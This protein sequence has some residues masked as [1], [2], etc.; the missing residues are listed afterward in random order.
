MD[1][2][3]LRYQSGFGNDFASEGLP[4]ALPVGQ[5]NPQKPAYGLYTEEINGTPFTAPR[6]ASRRCWTYRIRPSAVHEPFREIASGLIRSAPF[7]EAPAS[8][9]QLRWQPLPIPQE[10]TDFVAGL[11]TMGGNG[12]AAQQTGAAVHLYAANASMVDRFFY[13]ADGELLIVPQQ[14]ALTVRTELGVLHVA[15]TEFCVVPR[16]VKFRVEVEGPSR[17]YVCENYGAHFRLPELGP[18]GTSGLANS[19][20]FLSPVAAFEERDGDFRVVA[21]FLGKLFEA[22]IDH[23]PLDIVAWHGTYVPY[24]YDLK[25]FN[26][27]NT[28]TYDHPDPSIFSVLTAPTATPGT[29]NIDFGV[30]ADRWSVAENTFR[31]PPFHRNVCSEFVGLVQGRYIGKAEGFA[32]GCASLHNCMSG[33]GPDNDAFEAGSKAE[34]APQRFTDTLTIIFETQLVIK[35]T[36][37]AL[38]TELLERDYYKHWQGLKKNFRRTP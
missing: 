32:P 3:A 6:A 5:S 20:D 8:P 1:I 10:P 7:D 30:I 15:P 9:N 33:H 38:E 31:P 37:F 17:G 12:D 21:K 22:K 36:R 18:I 14:G 27:I 23:S 11:V 4:G 34:N 25:R 29:A 26:T 2:R 28:V 19:R 35:P 13:D 24:K 16:G